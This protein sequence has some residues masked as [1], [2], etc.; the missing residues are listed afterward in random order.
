VSRINLEMEQRESLLGGGSIGDGQFDEQTRELLNALEKK[1]MVE[2]L[3]AV[4]KDA[5]D[6]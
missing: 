4:R 2:K 5:G 3:Q 1:L 6:L